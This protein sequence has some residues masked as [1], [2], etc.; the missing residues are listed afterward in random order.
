MKKSL[1]FKAIV[2]LSGIIIATNKVAAQTPFYLMNN[3]GTLYTFTLEEKPRF[4]YSDQLLYLQTENIK[5]SFVKDKVSQIFWDN[6]LPTSISQTVEN[7]I[8]FK[9]SNGKLLVSGNPTSTIY[10][11]SLKGIL[12]GE[13]EPAGSE[14]ET[15]EI[16]NLASGTYL[17]KTSD[18]T[19]KFTK[20]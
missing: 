8:N 10:I 11:Y 19:F 3:T 20:Q 7:K 16:D 14:T 6:D 9:I 5:V 15:I 1:L 12:C 13:I 2:I 17:V 18:F 4:W